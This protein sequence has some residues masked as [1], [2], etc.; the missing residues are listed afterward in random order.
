METGLE[1]ANLIAEVQLY[2]A[3]VEIFR[4]EG[5]HPYWSPERLPPTDEEV[6]VEAQT[7]GIRGTWLERG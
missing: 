6:A 5:C 7:P 1:S 3:A 2:L 4:V